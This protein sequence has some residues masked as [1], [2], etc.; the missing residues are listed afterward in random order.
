M[1]GPPGPPAGPAG[2]GLPAPHGSAEVLFKTLN[3]LQTLLMSLQHSTHVSLESLTFVAGIDNSIDIPM[4]LLQI[5]MHLCQL[6]NECIYR[7][8]EL[9][10]HL[11]RSL[12]LTCERAPP[13]EYATAVL[14]P[15]MFMASLTKPTLHVC[16]TALRLL[17]EAF[18]FTDGNFPMSTMIRWTNHTPSSCP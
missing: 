4:A 18:G 7:V 3:T 11:L 15:N 5:P 14:N 8:V 10:H 16:T 6:C 12:W 13:F 2:N 1:T 9:L 17:E